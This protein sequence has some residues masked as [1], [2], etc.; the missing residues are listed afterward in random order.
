ML[1][2]E[3][4]GIRNVGQKLLIRE[5]IEP[6]KPFQMSS[7]VHRN[8]QWKVHNRNR[9][10]F[11]LSQTVALKGDSV[12]R[13]LRKCSAE[14]WYP[15]QSSTSSKQRTYIN[16]TGCIPS[17]FQKRKT[18]YTARWQLPG[19]WEGSLISQRVLTLMPWGGSYSSL[20]S[21][22]MLFTSLVKED[23]LWGFCLHKI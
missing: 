18:S 7:S 20:S 10:E 19:D 6:I 23:I 1:R 12:P 21:K 5:S 15:A 2:F 4:Q 17:R 11:S 14:V 3:K 9:K 8:D 16:M 13:A 22:Q